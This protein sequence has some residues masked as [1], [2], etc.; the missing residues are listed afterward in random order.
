[1]GVSSGKLNLFDLVLTMNQRKRFGVYSTC[2]IEHKHAAGVFITT[3][4][5]YLGIK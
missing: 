1:M 5:L 3:E 4:T 2:V